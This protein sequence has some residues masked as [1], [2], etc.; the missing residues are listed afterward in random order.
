MPNKAIAGWTQ[1]PVTAGDILS[2]HYDRLSAGGASNQL[3]AIYEV[4][5]S[6][7]TVRA[8]KTLSQQV[9][10]YPISVAVILAS[11]NAAEGT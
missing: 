3:T 9:G 2:I 8:V 10:S 7:G 11:I 1:V 6:G 4:K 5:D